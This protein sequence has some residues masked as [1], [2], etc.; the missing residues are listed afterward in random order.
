MPIKSRLP[1]RRYSSPN[2]HRGGMPST[3][4]SLHLALDRFRERT[5]HRGP[6]GSSPD[7][8]AAQRE[9]QDR[10]FDPAE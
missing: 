7:R 1:L 6:A 2:S 8:Q 4:V 3:P 5:V 9:A 10:E